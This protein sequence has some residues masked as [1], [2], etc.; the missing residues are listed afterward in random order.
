MVTEEGLVSIV[1]GLAT[2]Y[3]TRSPQTDELALVLPRWMWDTYGQERLTASFRRVG[4]QYVK[5]VDDWSEEHAIKPQL[6]LYAAGT[7]HTNHH[8]GQT[9]PDCEGCRYAD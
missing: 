2:S 8:I 5:L 6:L 7:W 9:N 3:R 4:V 1:D